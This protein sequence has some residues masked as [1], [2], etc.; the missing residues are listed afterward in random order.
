MRKSRGFTLFEVLISLAIIVILISTIAS[1]ISVAY[2]SKRSAEA[3]IENVRDVQTVGDI[4]VESV[5]SAL[6]PWLG[7]PAATQAAATL[8]ADTQAEDPTTTNVSLNNDGSL[9]DG[10]NLPLHL[11]GP[12]FGEAQYMSFFAS[13]AEPGAELRGDVRWVEFALSYTNQ[14]DGLQSLVRRVQTNLL[15]DGFDVE[16]PTSDGLP[17]QVL[18]NHVKDLRFQYADSSGNWYD[19]WDSVQSSNALPYAVSMD[20]TLSPLTENGPDRVIH[21]VASIWTA[22]P[23][24]TMPTDDTDTGVTGG[25]Q[26]GF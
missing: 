25:I 22:S 7:T 3:A 8:T 4:F 2:K 9:Q 20:L 17:D 5:Q 6:T 14:N 12:F 23:P 21:R 26:G 13:G 24:A 19:S 11:V 1:T 15:Q 10:T 16:N 18:I